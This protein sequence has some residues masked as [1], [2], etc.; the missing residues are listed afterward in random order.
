MEDTEE[1]MG[2]LEYAMIYSAGLEIEVIAWAIAEKLAHPNKPM[3]ECV[4]Y[5][6][7][8]WVK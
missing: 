4:N 8:E 7:A 6:L 5:G 3:I 1:I 2:A